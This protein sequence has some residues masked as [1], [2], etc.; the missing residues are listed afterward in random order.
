M[1]DTHGPGQLGMGVEMAVLTVHRDESL[2]ADKVEEGEQ[3][4]PV[5]VS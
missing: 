4:I 1:A 2:G 3:L 5:G